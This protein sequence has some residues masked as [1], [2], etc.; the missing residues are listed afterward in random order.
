MG[1]NRLTGRERMMQVCTAQLGK[2]YSEQ[3]PQGSDGD[4]HYWYPG[5][6]WPTHY[7]CSGLVRTTCWS[8]GI[9]VSNMNANDQWLQHL[10]G[11][12]ADDD[13]LLPA[14]IGAFL[15]GENEPGYAGHTGIVERADP[16][17]TVH[18][19]NAYDT[20]L[21]VIR[22]VT[23]RNADNSSGLGPLG[24]YRPVDFLPPAPRPVAPPT[25]AELTARRLVGLATPDEALAARNNGWALFVWDGSRFL[26]AANDQPFD[27]PEYANK[28]WHNKRA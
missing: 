9:P 10:G 28:A 7:D 18:I 24:W 17:G 19:I 21:G 8:A 25:Q 15:G 14:D 26:P 11:V 3:S 2:G 27:T 13:L 22:S 20:A 12:V 6:P 1:Y 23:H 16:D 4:G 5:Q